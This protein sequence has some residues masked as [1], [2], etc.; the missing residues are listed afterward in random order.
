MWYVYILRSE[1]DGKIYI[2]STNDLKR[3]VKQHNSGLVNSTKYRIPLNLESY[4]A[5]ISEDKART[6]EQYFKKGSGHA[7][8][9]KRLLDS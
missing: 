7:F 2:G 6:L 1:I 8:L 5:V 9:H 3:R 4:I